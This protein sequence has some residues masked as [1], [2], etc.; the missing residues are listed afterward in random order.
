VADADGRRGGQLRGIGAGLAHEAAL[1]PRTNPNEPAAASLQ[2]FLELSQR[3][4]I[5]LLALRERVKDLEILR[6]A[7]SAGANGE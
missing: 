4:S 5:E 1:P 7:R 3:Q 6:D 2:K